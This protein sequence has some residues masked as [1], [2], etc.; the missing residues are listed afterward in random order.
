M[1]RIRPDVEKRTITPHSPLPDCEYPINRIYAMGVGEQT[2]Q[3]CLTTQTVFFLILRNLYIS[4]FGHLFHQTGMTPSPFEQCLK[5][6][7][8]VPVLGLVRPRNLSALPEIA[9]FIEKA[10]VSSP[11]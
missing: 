2:Q 3:V 1:D 9:H 7:K 6:A 11:Q 5:L 10:V 8:C 4:R